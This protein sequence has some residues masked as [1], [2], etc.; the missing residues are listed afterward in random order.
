MGTDV[1]E[2]SETSIFGL[3]FDSYDTVLPYTAA[4]RLAFVLHIGKV[5]GS[6]PQNRP[7]LFTFIYVSIYLSLFSVV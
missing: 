4:Q 5:P 3:Y 7:R 1:S 6:L 2:E